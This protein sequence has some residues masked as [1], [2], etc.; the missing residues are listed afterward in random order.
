MATGPER[1]KAVDAAG[2]G[3]MRAS[4]GDRALVIET[5]KAAFVQGRLTKDELDARAGQA[6]AARTDADLAALTADLPAGAPG[7]APPVAQARQPISTSGEAG[8]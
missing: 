6:F 7:A 2:L 5:L 8:M 4:H 3:P 1:G